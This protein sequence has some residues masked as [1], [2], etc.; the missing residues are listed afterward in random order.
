VPSRGGI[1]KR[2]ATTRHEIGSS[3]HESTRRELQ[4]ERK[5]EERK[6]NRLKKSLQTKLQLG[7]GGSAAA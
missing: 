5:S 7:W 3:K 6:L 4:D 2:Y 1:M